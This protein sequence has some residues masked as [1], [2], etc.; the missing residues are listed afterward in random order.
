MSTQQRRSI[1]RYFPTEPWLEEYRE[2][3]NENDAYAEHSAGWGV[4]FD[5]SFI[6]Q[7][8]DVPLESTAIA[9]LPPEI[10]EA[11]EDEL[12][13]L[14]ADRIETILEEAPANVCESIEA[15]EG[16]LE[17]R[18]AAE[19]KETS[20]AEIPDRIWPELRPEL[21]DLLDE[22]ITQLEENVA[23]DGTIY[24][25]LDLYDGECEAVDTVTDL[26]DQEC[27]FRLIGEYGK[28]TKLV[29]GDGDVIDMLMSGEF[30]IDGDM[31]KILQYSDAAVDLAEVAADVDSR[32][33]F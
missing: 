3:I 25:Y 26:D 15:R 7:I 11:V 30:E 9:D 8:E 4:N 22:L 19:V 27:G 5:G 29:R 20:M 28:W 1:E 14:D 17:D 6:F 18:V 2:A 31:Q 33:I 13:A 32:F 24:A 23:D 16:S 21:P 12:S 10:V